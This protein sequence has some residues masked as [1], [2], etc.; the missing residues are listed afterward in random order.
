VARAAIAQARWT[1]PG[2]AIGWAQQS[3]YI[4]AVGLVLGPAAVG[5]MAA[6]RLFVAPLLLLAVAWSRM[7]LPQATALLADGGEAVL[8]ARCGRALRFALVGSGLYLVIPGAAF[9]FG[10]DRLL[11]A[12]YAGCEM[13]VLAWAGFAV[14]HLVR[15]IASTAVMAQMQFRPLFAMTLVSAG[16][17]IGLVILL[18]KPL[19][20]TGA[21]VGITS[22]EALLAGLAW[23]ALLTRPV[24]ERSAVGEQVQGTS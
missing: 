20:A 5:E 14:I 16:I 4:Y 6:A 13:Q 22:G 18:I 9:L 8:L 2:A 1:L 23:R 21:I 15:T 12:E 3:G 19:G 7:F 24:P 17:S 10:V 11:P